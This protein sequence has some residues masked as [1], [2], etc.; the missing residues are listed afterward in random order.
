MKKAGHKDESARDS[1]IIQVNGVTNVIA[2]FKISQMKVLMVIIKAL[3]EPLKCRLNSAR[4]GSDAYEKALP[5]VAW[6]SLEMTRELV[7]PVKEF[8]FGANNTW[9]LARTLEDLRQ[10]SCRFP[11]VREVHGRMKVRYIFSGLITHYVMEPYT[12]VV[13]LY[14]LDAMIG[15]LLLVEEGY[16]RYS[17]TQAMSFRNKYTVRLYWLIASWAN[18]GGFC[19]S[20]DSMRRLLS[21][22]GVHIRLDNFYSAVLNKARDEM[23]EQSVM[24]FEYRRLRSGDSEMICFKVKRHYTP[25][26]LE[27]LRHTAR[28]YMFNFCTSLG[29]SEPAVLP[30]LQEVEPEDLPVFCEKLGEVKTYI[31]QH[32]DEIVNPEGYVITTVRKFLENWAER[33]E[34]I[35]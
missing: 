28:D 3:Q 9:Y 26:D 30:L 6:S 21:L 13:K 32:R 5:P 24:Y 4:L 11:E 8:G 10:V 14:M 22:E 12:G 18:R 23:K 29:L 16:G 33:F 35:R 15:R 27:K 19:I 17:L 7:I 34:E 20:L 2:D 1:V 31:I 25:E